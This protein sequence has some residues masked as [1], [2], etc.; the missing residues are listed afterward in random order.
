MFPLNINTEYTAEKHLKLFGADPDLT[1]EGSFLFYRQC[2]V[3]PELLKL[4][5]HPPLF[6]QKFEL[7][8]N[9]HQL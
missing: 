5:Y 8:V 7:F 6:Q 3:C 9:C 4:V 1:D 2:L